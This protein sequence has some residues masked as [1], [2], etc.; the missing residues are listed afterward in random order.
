MHPYAVDVYM[1]NLFLRVVVASLALTG[2]GAALAQWQWLDESG[3]KV[4]SDRPPPLTVPE[5]S[6]LKAPRGEAMPTTQSV[7]VHSAVGGSS[8]APA[9]ADSASAPSQED[10]ELKARA[11]QIQAQ[12]EQKSPDNSA[13]IAQKNADIERA[14]EAARKTNCANAR[15]RLAQ[16]EP[17]KRVMTTDANG[18]AGF[19]SDESRAAERSTA[20]NL[21]RSNCQ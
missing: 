10:Q 2:A 5:G 18:N 16:L 20:H 13:E 1:L 4:Y 7:P 12:D 3:S 8:A 14:N 15:T 9:A 11:E 17:G 21:I 19:M 6:I